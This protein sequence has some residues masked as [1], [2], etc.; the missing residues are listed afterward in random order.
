MR[1]LLIVRGAPASGKTTW[2]LDEGLFQY[3]ITPDDYR[4]PDYINGYSNRDKQFKVWNRVK[5]LVEDRMKQGQSL[6]VLDA[7]DSGYD[8]WMELASKYG[9]EVWFKLMKTPT[10]ECIRRN[11]ERISFARLPDAVMEA[12][13]KWLE[14]NPVPWPARL[15]PDEADPIIFFGIGKEE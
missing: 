11:S 12:A 4:Q 1:D 10:E 14:D 15:L 5:H 3:T 9:Y 6:I 8:Q 7:Q 2:C 13:F